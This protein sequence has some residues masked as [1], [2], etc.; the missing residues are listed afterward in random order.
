MSTFLIILC[1]VSL[2]GL[3]V[4]AIYYF[5][6]VKNFRIFISQLVVLIICFSILY[7]NFFAFRTPTARGDK[8]EIY[9]V[10]ILYLCMLLG[11]LAQYLYT[12]FGQSRRKRH[13]KKFD[14]GLF[15]AP[16]FTS[17][18]IF[19]P[20]LAALQNTT[21]N[22]RNL[23]TTK[24]MIFFVAFENGFFW[25]EFFDNRRELKEEENNEKASI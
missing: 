4:L 15:I 25:K 22:L 3:L 9:F 16:V 10:I 23:T 6:T 14:F 24:M 2:V 13:K 7:V 17:P 5:I 11:M 21:I 8:T 12:W 20:L 19:I 1:T 18:I